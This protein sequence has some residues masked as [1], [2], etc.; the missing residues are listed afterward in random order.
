DRER[1]IRGRL[2]VEAELANR[3]SEFL[4]RGS[5][6]QKKELLRALTELPLR[7]ADV[8]DLDAN[9]E[10]PSPPVY[11]RIGN[12]TEPIVFFGES[13]ARFAESLDPLLNSEDA[14]LRMPAGRAVLLVRETR[15]GEVNQLAGPAGS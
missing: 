1:A 6:E 15:F 8:Y 4:D 12:D 5:V 3:F 2:K 13:A 11:N 7:R 9:M 10:K 14:E